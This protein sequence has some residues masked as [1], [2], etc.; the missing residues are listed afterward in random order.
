MVHQ[1]WN[2]SLPPPFFHKCIFSPK[3]TALALEFSLRKCERLS[4]GAAPSAGEC[5]LTAFL[6][7]PSFGPGRVRPSPIKGTAGAPSPAW[8]GRPG[9]SSCWCSHRQDLS[10]RGDTSPQALTRIQKYLGLLFRYMTFTSS[11]PV[12]IWDLEKNTP[13]KLNFK[14]YT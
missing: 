3:I 9:H 7:I 13:K 6:Q 10:N 14:L 11:C 8:K 1:G 4:L 12:A 2:R 5:P